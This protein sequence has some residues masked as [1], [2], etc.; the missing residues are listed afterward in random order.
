MEKF[1]PLFFS[2]MPVFRLFRQN[3]P[4]GVNL[5]PA[6]NEGVE[7]HAGG[8]LVA[9]DGD[10]LHGGVD[11]LLPEHLS[12]HVEDVDVCI[13]CVLGQAEAYLRL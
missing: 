9:L 6:N 8:E 10:A 2:G 4:F 12:R 5:F 13:L 1:P 11:R 3:H 7:I